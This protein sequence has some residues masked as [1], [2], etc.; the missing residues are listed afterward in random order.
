MYSHVCYVLSDAR[1]G[2]AR[3]ELPAA[4]RP[5][6]RAESRPRQRGGQL[7]AAAGDGPGLRR[8]AQDLHGRGGRQ[9][10]VRTWY[11]RWCRW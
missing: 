4:V 6:H 8:G 7:P 9:E 10:S 5:D 2:D 1:A 11:E 3:L